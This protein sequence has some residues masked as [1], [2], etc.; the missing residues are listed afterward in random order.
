MPQQEVED[1]SDEVEEIKEDR[2][3]SDYFIAT[4][5]M[6]AHIA[7]LLYTGYIIYVS[8]PGSS[9]YYLQGVPPLKPYWSSV[10]G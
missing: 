10:C 4:N 6:V 9:E 2:G 5:K 1:N 7:S 3:Y 8:Q